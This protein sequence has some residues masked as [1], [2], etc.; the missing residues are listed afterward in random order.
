MCAETQR[1]TQTTHNVYVGVFK[2]LKVTV[3]QQK[4]FKTHFCCVKNT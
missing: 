3:S 2:D 1:V 4:T